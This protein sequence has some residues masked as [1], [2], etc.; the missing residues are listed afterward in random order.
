[1]FKNHFPVMKTRFFGKNIFGIFNSHFLQKIRRKI[2]IFENGK[3]QKNVKGLTFQKCCLTSILD[4]GIWKKKLSQIKHIPNFPQINSQPIITHRDLPWKYFWENHD[5][6]HF[7]I[8]SIYSTDPAVTG[9]C[10]DKES[11]CI[12]KLIWVGI[13]CVLQCLVL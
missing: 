4:F 1:M 3:F 6:C 8:Y 10:H 9:H 2:L 5:F 7:C 11:M 12:S 13:K